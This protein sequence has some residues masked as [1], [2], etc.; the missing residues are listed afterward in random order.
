MIALFVGKM[1]G[2]PNLKQI[3][4]QHSIHHE[5][6]LGNIHYSIVVKEPVSILGFYIKCKWIA[7]S[8]SHQVIFK[9]FDKPSRSEKKNQGMIFP[10]AFDK[11]SLKPFVACFKV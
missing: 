8:E 9:C 1:N 2:F 11:F 3:L 5:S 10:G 4:G 6:A 7:G